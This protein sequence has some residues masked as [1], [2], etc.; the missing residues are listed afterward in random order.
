[1]QY[2][3]AH[4]KGANHKIAASSPDLATPAAKDAWYNLEVPKHSKPDDHKWTIIDSSHAWFVEDVKSLLPRTQIVRN[5]KA[6][7][8]SKPR[9]TQSA[10]TAEAEPRS[11][12]GFQANPELEVPVGNPGTP[13]FGESPDFT[14]V[15]SYQ[16][17]AWQKERISNI[18][19]GEKVRDFLKEI[20]AAR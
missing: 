19:I 20:K 5:P 11:G 17:A 14:D 9:D 2:K 13:F 10:E 15:M 16:Q 4:F 18:K 6:K 8:T 12:G 1:M 7:Y 3:L